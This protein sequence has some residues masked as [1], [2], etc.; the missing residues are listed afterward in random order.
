MKRIE[1]TLEIEAPADRVWALTVD[2]ESWPAMTPTMSSVE[3]LDDGPIGIAST[4]RVKQPAQRARVW[5]VTEFEPGRVFAWRSRAFGVEMTGTHRI[6][7]TPHGS[8]NTVSIDLVGRGAGLVSRLFGGQ[9]RR[10]LAKENEGFK[11]AAEA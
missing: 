11:R 9:I 5:T 7:S 2:V 3:R 1:H 4:A 6:A 8:S 10:S